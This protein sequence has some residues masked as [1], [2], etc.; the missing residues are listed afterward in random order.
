MLCFSAGRDESKPAA[1]DVAKRVFSLLPAHKQK[2]VEFTHYGK[3]RILQ[4]SREY[5]KADFPQ[6]ILN[7]ASGSGGG[8]MADGTG[9]GKCECDCVLSIFIL[10]CC[11]MNLCCGLTTMNLNFFAGGKGRDSGAGGGAGGKSGE[12]SSDTVGAEFLAVLQAERECYQAIR[13]SKREVELIL[14]SRQDEEAEITVTKTI[15]ETV[16]DRQGAPKKD[17]QEEQEEETA[18]Q[19]DYL[20][21]FLPEEARGLVLN[22][23]EKGAGGDDDQGIELTKEQAQRAA[24]ACLNALKKRLVERASIIQRRLDSENEKLSKRQAL[25]QRSR[26]ASESV[27]DEYEK[28]CQE[29]MFRIQILEKRFQKHEETAFQKYEEMIARLDADPR[30]AAKNT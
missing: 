25:F 26:D 9:G 15:F 2:V 18:V 30:L 7:V 16:R 3:N 5:V 29:A 11:E 17:E 10:C 14:K 8:G 1:K 12:S 22:Q 23:G 28:F 13:A 27:D 24:D 19:S 4:E 21:A 6:N 20:T